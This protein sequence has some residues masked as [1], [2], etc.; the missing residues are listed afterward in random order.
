MKVKELITQLL[1]FDQEAEISFQIA[2][3]CC[4][5]YEFLEN[6]DTDQFDY[7]EKGKK[8]VY[9]NMRFP[10]LEIMSSCIAS[11]IAKRAVDAHRNKEPFK[12]QYTSYLHQEYLNRIAKKKTDG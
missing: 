3:G 8:H 1:E 2:D 7:M 5:D 9:V 10:S 12:Q 6:P 4:G 11:G